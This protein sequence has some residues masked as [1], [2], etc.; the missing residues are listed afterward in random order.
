MGEA[1]VTD[2]HT[3]SRQP[4]LHR[5]DLLQTA[6]AGLGGLTVGPLLPARGARA[7]A[8]T[9]HG[10][11]VTPDPI[12]PKIQ[13]S[14]LAVGLADFS[15]PTPTSASRPFALLNFLYHAGD[16]SGRIFTNDSGG[17]L[18]QLD[19][20]TGAA[21]PFLDLRQARDNAFLPGSVQMGLRSFA[22]HPD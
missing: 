2:E 17:V 11:V 1:S 22:F 6:L 7:A 15:T 19:P 3:P 16:G 14:G 21:Q 12:K 9:A 5:R 18:W 20:T 10:P 4:S 13:K 8:A